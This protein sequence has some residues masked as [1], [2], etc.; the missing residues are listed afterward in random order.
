MDNIATSAAWLQELIRLMGIDVSVSH[1]PAVNL[2][3]AENKVQQSQNPN[4]WLNINAE[5]LQD[6]QLQRLI[7]QD[8]VVI[9]AMQYLTNLVMNHRPHDS[10]EGLPHSHN[11]YTVELN[12]YRA[13][14]LA[15]LHSMIEETLQRVRETG[16]EVVLKH[17]SAADRRYVHQLLDGFADIENHSYGKE[18]HRYLVVKLKN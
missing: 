17:L 8:G 4:Y 10:E 14:R 9:D 2:I 13:N 7:G 15:S 11:F 12:S 16:E 18:P 3:E 6:E 1:V 5:N